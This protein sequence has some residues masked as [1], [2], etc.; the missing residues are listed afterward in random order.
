[1]AK[2]YDATTN[3]NPR[4]CM[5]RCWLVSMKTGVG[6]TKDYMTD[7]VQSYF[8]QGTTGSNAGLSGVYN[9]LIS[10]VN[11][12][13]LTVH[14]TW[15]WKVGRLGYWVGQATTDPQSTYSNMFSNNDFP[16]FVNKRL[17]LTKYVPKITKWDENAGITSSRHVFLV[18][19]CIPADNVPLTLNERIVNLQYKIEAKYTDF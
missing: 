6:A 10:P 5:V 13:L 17:N 15:T 19:D 2:Q 7:I 12:D 11:D 1:M 16:S 3:P 18:F 9:D 14:K 8:L 4:P